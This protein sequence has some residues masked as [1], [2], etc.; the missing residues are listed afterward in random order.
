VA[1]EARNA[2]PSWS[3]EVGERPW[4]IAVTS[5]GRTLY[6]ANGPSNDVSVVDVATRAVTARIAV[7]QSPWGV[8]IL[9]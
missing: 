9:P 2:T 1:I 5:D 6:T 3:V 8:A 4:G 7:G